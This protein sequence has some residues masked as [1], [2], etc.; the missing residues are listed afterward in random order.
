MLFSD[1]FG[2]LNGGGKFAFPLLEHVNIGQGEVTRALV[3]AIVIHYYEEVVVNS[4]HSY[5]FELEPSTSASAACLALL[6]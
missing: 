6:F 5:S 4:P 3:R 1:S 2:K